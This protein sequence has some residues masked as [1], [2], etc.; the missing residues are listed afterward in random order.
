MVEMPI[1]IR[2]YIVQGLNFRSRDTFSNSDAFVKVEFGDQ[3]I[4]DRAH[5]IP[6]QS[7]PVF[8]RRFQLSGVIPRDTI[9]KVSVHDQDSMSRNDLIGVTKIDIEDRVRTKYLANCGLPEEFNSFGYNTWRNSS[10]PSEIL[11]NLCNELGISS[12]RYFHDYVQ[13][14]G[15][16]FNDSSKIT[17]DENVKERLALSALRNF[18]RVPGIGYTMVPEHV[19]TRSLYREDRP[20]VEQGK[21]LMWVE[22]FDPKKTIPEPIDITPLPPRAYEL[23]LII[24]NAK[25]IVLDEKNIF[26][27]QMSDIYVKG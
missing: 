24:W 11:L 2:V 14:A 20:G 10:L 3:E 1:L 23:R 16:N 22:I 4:S 12:P 17:R 13:V 6:N 27:K 7:N 15:I 9:L 21:L 18:S 5:Y 25:N 19:E 8:G 26:G